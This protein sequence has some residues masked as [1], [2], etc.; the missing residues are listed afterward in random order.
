MISIIIPTFNNFDFISETVTSII[1]QSSQD[2]ECI[3]V[4]DRSALDF[5]TLIKDLIENKSNFLLIER[6]DNRLK[7]ANS[8]RNIG[9]ENAKGNFLMFLDAEDVIADNCVESRLKHITED[10]NLFIFP[11]RSFEMEISENGK[12]INRYPKHNEGYLNM[13]LSYNIPWP[14]TSMLIR[15]SNIKIL[16]NESLKRFQDID[17]SIRLLL[18]ENNRLLNFD[19]IDPDCFYRQDLS[20][21]EKFNNSDFIQLIVTS[22]Y[23]F[24]KTIIPIIQNELEERDWIRLREFYKIIFNRYIYRNSNILNGDHKKI[25]KLLYSK[26]ILTVK[27]F[28]LYRLKENSSCYNSVLI[29]F[30]HLQTFKR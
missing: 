10:Y 14:I 6:P 29:I 16:F 11:M 1:N 30:K 5:L 25:R 8:C 19:K 22:T 3:I 27:D 24:F 18:S 17:F 21:K 2:W 13:F 28:F 12:I 26:K 7:G 9:I 23:L 20:H 15:R 4:D